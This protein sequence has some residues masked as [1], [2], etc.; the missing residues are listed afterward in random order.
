MQK[1]KSILGGKTSLPNKKGIPGMEV[2]NKINDLVPFSTKHEEG[3]PKPG[4]LLKKKGNDTNININIP[5]QNG[6]RENNLKLI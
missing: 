1:K 5:F 6:I 4:G 2:L 3:P